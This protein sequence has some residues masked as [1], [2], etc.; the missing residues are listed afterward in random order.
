MG[1]GSA[2]STVSPGT[3]AGCAQGTKR[4]TALEPSGPRG[5]AVMLAP[6]PSGFAV[7]PRYLLA[8]LPR[9]ATAEQTG[10]RLYGRAHNTLHATARGGP[11]TGV[12][13]RSLGTAPCGRPVCL[14]GQQTPATITACVRG[15]EQEWRG[16][17]EEP[18]GPHSQG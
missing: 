15:S 18:Q 1:V 10:A 14:T 6:C 7:L 4:Q 11:P 16:A 2:F 3:R 17:R 5:G 8:C 13:K 9:G 12:T